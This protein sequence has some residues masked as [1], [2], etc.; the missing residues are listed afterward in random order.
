MLIEKDLSLM[1]KADAAYVSAGLRSSSKKAVRNSKKAIVLGGELD[2]VIG[3][4][5]RSQ[6]QGPRAV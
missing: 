2:G 3:T 4:V 6:T 1:E 5:F